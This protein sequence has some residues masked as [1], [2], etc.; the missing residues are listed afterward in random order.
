MKTTLKLKI[1]P[2]RGYLGL[3]IYPIKLIKS[4][5]TIPLNFNYN[6]TRF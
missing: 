5:E 4:R 6:K 2:I 1:H 3:I